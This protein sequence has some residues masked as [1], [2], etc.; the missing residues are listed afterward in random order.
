MLA[1]FMASLFAH[2]QN[3]LLIPPVISGDS[4][5]LTLQTSTYSFFQGQITNTMGAN[6]NILGPTLILNQGDSVRFWVNNQLPDTTTIHWH[7]MH[8]SSPNDGGPHTIILP[9][10]TW[11]PS[12]TVRDK[13]GTYWYHPHLHK[14]TD[15]HVSKGIAGLILV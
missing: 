1:I 2:S 13:A 5:S 7:G 11:T 4:V 12:F 3:S 8:V 9:G 10:A 15:I 14:K 6:G